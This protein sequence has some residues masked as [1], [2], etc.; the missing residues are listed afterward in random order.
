MSYLFVADWNEISPGEFYRK[1][2]LYSMGWPQQV[3]LENFSL[4]GASYG[5]PMAII[6]D[7]KKLLRVTAA[8]PVKPIISLYTAPGALI[9]QIKVIFYC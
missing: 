1:T 2:E 7:D 8:V 6:K 9:S 4:V 5:G 3:D